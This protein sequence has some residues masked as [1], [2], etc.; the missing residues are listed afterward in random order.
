MLKVDGNWAEF[1][2]EIATEAH[3]FTETE[4]D[5]ELTLLHHIHPQVTAEEN[6][7]LKNMSDAEEI[8][9]VVF[10]LNGDGACGPDGFTGHFYQSCWEIIGADLVGFVKGRNISENVLLAQ[11]IIID[12]EKRGKPANVVIKLDMAKAYD[13]VNWKFLVQVLEQMGFD[14]NVMDM[15]WR[16][17]AN[18][19]YSILINGQSHGFF[20]STRGVKQG[21]PLSLTLFILA[22]EVLS[23]ALN[24]L[25]YNPDFKSFGR[26]KWSENLN[27]LAYADDTIIFA[28]ADRQSLKLIVGVVE[29]AIGLARGQ[30][31]VMT[32]NTLWSNF[33]WNKYYKR[34]R[35]QVVKWKGGSQVWKMMLQARDNIDQKIWWEPMCGQASLWFDNWTQLGTLYDIIPTNQDLDPTL[36]EVNQLTLNGRGNENMMLELF[37]NEVCEHVQ[38]ALGDYQVSEERDMPWWVSNPKGKF[39]VGSAWEILRNRN[40]PQEGIM[41]IWEK[42][43]PFKVSFLVWRIWPQRI[44]IGEVRIRNRIIDSTLCGCCENNAQESFNHLFFFCPDANFLWRWFRGAAGLQ[45][46]FIQLRQTI[47]RWWNEECVTKARPLYK[48]VPASIMWQLWKKRNVVKHG[49]KMSKHSTMMEVNRN[50]YLIALYKY[51]WLTG[52]P[53]T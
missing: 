22:A 26:P 29:E 4:A 28:A 36:D 8:K 48:A 53:K 34:Y 13:R 2:E 52:M 19:W 27:H 44:P 6:T 15:I 1:E 14:A 5:T 51:P 37:N 10:E 18:K 38:K 40:D 33:M 32:K 20:H 49:G 50:I 24:H 23:R 7:Y 41:N 21:D 9:R 39:S 25:F 12:I 47:Y 45:G 42:G 35:P 43:I 16:V 46:S 30:F 31:P 11:E 17:V 3:Q